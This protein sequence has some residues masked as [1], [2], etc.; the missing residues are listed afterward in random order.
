[1]DTARNR[2]SNL[3]YNYPT[4]ALW[5]LSLCQNQ[6][7]HSPQRTLLHGNVFTMPSK[8]NLNR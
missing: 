1:M 7:L 8:G 5:M 3:L 2:G 4:A 6:S